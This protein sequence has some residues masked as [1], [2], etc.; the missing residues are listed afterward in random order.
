MPMQPE[1]AANPLPSLSNFRDL[2]GMSLGD[3]RLRP[4]LFYR[5]PRPTGLAVHDAAWLEQLGPVAIIDFRGVAEREAQPANLS[6]T[7]MARRMFL[8]IEPSVAA[9]LSRAETQGMMD[10]HAANR[11]MADSYRA[12]VRDNLDVFGA[13]LRICGSA[14]GPLMFHCSAGKDRT[15]FA[16]ALL[17]S[18]LGASKDDIMADYL[19]TR[20]DWHVP[21]DIRAEAVSANRSA[22]LGVEP[23]YL[24]AAFEELDKR[25]NGAAQFAQSCLGG[26]QA[27]LAF[28]ERASIAIA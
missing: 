14:D 11:A 16:A 28:R 18:A 20:T 3:R 9:R 24:N 22:L 21:D 15:G 23:E 1:I 25:A 19:R 17:L 6:P 7:L 10:D 12:Y 13:F 2:G 4:N 8:P 27:L 5:C 26:A